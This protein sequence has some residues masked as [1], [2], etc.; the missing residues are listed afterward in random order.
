[1]Y[2]ICSASV[3]KCIRDEENHWVSH[4]PANTDEVFQEQLSECKNKYDLDR[5]LSQYKMYEGLTKVKSDACRSEGDLC[6]S[7]H[8]ND[9]SGGRLGK[10]LFRIRFGQTGFWD[11]YGVN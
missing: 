7:Q 3:P 6:L 8:S 10:N 5:L 9:I 1:V 4:L 2:H 11:N